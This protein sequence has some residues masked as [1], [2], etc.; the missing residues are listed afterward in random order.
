MSEP[1]FFEIVHNTRAIK[2]LKSDPVPLELIR[3]VLDAGTKAPSGVDSQ[4]WRFVVVRDSAT[5][6]RIQER[7]LHFTN[8]RFRTL[9]DSLEPD[10]AP[11]TRML[12]TVLYLAEHLHE[13]PVLLFACAERDWPATVPQHERVGTAP[14]PYGSIYPCV[15]NIL[16]ACRAL[17]LGA[18]LTT[19][20]QMFEGEL[21]D[22]LAVPEDYAIVALIP[23]GYPKGKF[24]PVT[25]TAA[26]A[27]THFD[28]WGNGDADGQPVSLFPQDSRESG[29]SS[30]ADVV[31]R[32]AQG[33]RR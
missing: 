10:N 21:H 32:D 30:L 9:V 14:A 12:R 11:Y 7:Y 29:A 24:G 31:E 26:E 6:K 4:P 1:G 25:R 5:K 20:H 28:R 23:I 15:Q 33:G 2:R 18:S 17:G 16:L 8:Q 22:W 27:L 19:I 13:A 3:K